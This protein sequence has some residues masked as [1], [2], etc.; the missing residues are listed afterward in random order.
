MCGYLLY[1]EQPRLISRTL[2]CTNPRQRRSKRA[3][4]FRFGTTPV[5]AFHFL[6]VRCKHRS[7]LRLPSSLKSR[8]RRRGAGLPVLVFP[9]LVFPVLVALVS[10]LLLHSVVEAASVQAAS[11]QTGPETRTTTP[12]GTTTP[13]GI[14]PATAYEPPKKPAA[15]S[16]PGVA[17]NRAAH[18][19][20]T[21]DG[22]TTDLLTFIRALEAPRGYDDYE[23]RIPIAPP[24]PLTTMTVGEVLDWQVDIRRSGAASTAAG[25]YQIIYLTLK[26]L[27]STYGI[28]RDLLFDASLQDRLARLL[29]SECGTR[30]GAGAVK[31]HPRFG[32]CLAGI[33]AA[34]PLTEGA[35]KGRSAHQGAAGNRALT[36]PETVL[37][38][39]AGHPV[40]IP[41]AI[42]GPGT[43]STPDPAQDPAPRGRVD[44]PLEADIRLGFGALRITD[45]NAAM[46]AARQNNTLT[47]SLRPPPA[48]RTWKVDPY[49]SQ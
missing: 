28:S 24:K 44:Q 11:T 20:T 43:R 40:G 19:D 33:W 42:S 6:R 36:R 34:L 16:D 25:G 22:T 26:R 17:I 4:I 10:I 47:P 2:P 9:V 30:P 23:R 1:L 41:V 31:G 5:R 18:P 49:A 45:V 21:T 48:T 37:A 14:T 39:L 35:N 13:P 7:H 27:V 15:V 12:T 38:L 29:I 3:G 46:R 32:N 8:R